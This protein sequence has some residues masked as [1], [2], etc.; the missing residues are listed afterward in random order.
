MGGNQR[1]PWGMDTV[2]LVWTQVL[3]VPFG[4][5]PAY[6]P[7]DPAPPSPT[8]LWAPGLRCHWPHGPTRQHTQRNHSH[9]WTEPCPPEGPGPWGPGPMHQCTGMPPGPCSQ[10]PSPREQQGSFSLR[11]SLTQQQADASPGPPQPC[12]LASRPAPVLGPA[13]PRVLPARK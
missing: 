1:S 11:A 7:R 2:V 5:P 6:W 13:G 4:P 10:R 9:P 12:R 8:S 3:A